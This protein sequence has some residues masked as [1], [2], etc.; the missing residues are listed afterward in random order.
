MRV[1]C[2]T[3]GSND[4]PRRTCLCQAAGRQARLQAHGIEGQ[5]RKAYGREQ[6]TGTIRYFVAVV[7]NRGYLELGQITLEY[8]RGGVFLWNI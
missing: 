7:I 3:P 6:A 4:R 2:C 8:T 1:P 5:T